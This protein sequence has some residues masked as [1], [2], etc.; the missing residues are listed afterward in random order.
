MDAR[1]TRRGISA[2]VFWGGIGVLAL[3]TLAVLFAG[4]SAHADEQE[5]GPLDGLTTLVSETVSTV[6][7]PVAPVVTQVVAPV[8]TQVVAPVQQAA[9]AVVAAVTQPITKAPVVGPAVAPVVNAVT[10]TADAVVA[11][12][13]DTLTD[14]PVS[15]ITDPVLEAVSG[16]PVVGGLASD[17]GLISAVGDVVDVVDDTT[18]LLGNVTN[19]TVPPVLEAIDPTNPPT[20]QE[21][22]EVSS[23][24]VEPAVVT[25]AV[26][27]REHAAATPSDTST[28]G[29]T[30][31]APPSTVSAAIES[32]TT[33]L[34]HTTPVPAG[35]PPGD[36]LGTAVPAS[37]SAGSGGGNGVSA[38]RLSDANASP[39]R[40]GER[41]S[42]AS[43][44]E[45][46][47]SPVADTDVSPD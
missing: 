18:A 32:A 22:G 21:P 11:P 34:D 20:T 29:S 46:P 45:L 26:L 8:V 14:A 39:L 24:I 13:T 5:D 9:P 44:D 3:T 25:D 17:L 36:P 38:A 33:A 12:V 23:V 43:D 27:P 10:E 7:A 6:T 35:S 30:A 41:I 1:A 47:P 15:Q 16:I 28:S 31:V 40:A 2:G 42:G 19:E 37:S 4:G